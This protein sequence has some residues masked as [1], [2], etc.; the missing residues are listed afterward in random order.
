MYIVNN[1]AF[2]TQWNNWSNKSGVA[3]SKSDLK[4][5]N[6]SDSRSKCKT[7]SKFTEKCSSISTK[8]NASQL[9]P[10]A[11]TIESYLQSQP[12]VH[13]VG[14]NETAQSIASDHAITVQQLRY[15]LV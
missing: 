10:G 9:A 15:V 12:H 6:E 13:A 1:S 8:N 11:T 4:K 3:N 14:T 2:C 5:C 7:K